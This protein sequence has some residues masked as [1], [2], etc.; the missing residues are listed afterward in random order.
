[1]APAL[2]KELLEIQAAIECG[3]TVKRVRDMIRTFL[4]FLTIIT[5]LAPVNFWKIIHALFSCIPRFEIRPLAL[6]PTHWSRNW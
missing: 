4:T 3:F 6:L 5:F 2:S 1:M